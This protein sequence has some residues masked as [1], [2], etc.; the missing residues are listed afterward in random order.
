MIRILSYNIFWKAMTGKHPKCN[1]ILFDKSTG[2]Y[3]NNCLNNVVNF[4]DSLGPY[5][6]V[7]LQEANSWPTI[8]ILSNYLSPMTAICYKP[9]VEDIVVFYNKS[10]YHLD[11]SDNIIKGYLKDKGRPLII[12]FFQENI[13][14]INIHAGHHKDIL[15]LDQHLERILNS[16]EYIA[17][18]FIFLEKFQ[19]YHII[20]MGDFND[21]LSGSTHTIFSNSFF[22]MGKGRT[23]YGVNNKDTCC[24]SGLTNYLHHPR[25][26][27]HILSSYQNIQSK[28][29]PVS[30]ASDHFP[31]ISEIFI[32][33]IIGRNRIKNI[34]YDFDGVLHVDVGPP[35]IYGQRH[36]FSHR[37][38]NL[39][40]FDKII[41]QIYLELQSGHNVF[42]ITA[43]S[44]NSKT[45]IKNF[46]SG[47]IL[48]N[49]L[50][51]I[52]IYCSAGKNK[53]QILDQL[54]INIF[55]DDSCVR[56]LELQKSILNGKLPNME[57]LYYVK[58]ELQTWV[59]VNPSSNTN[60][61]IL[62]HHLY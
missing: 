13:C 18:K 15:L 39:K 6:F 10:K 32:N 23:L 27:D 46:L 8:Q 59:F 16:P 43:R 38:N 25:P 22:Q 47:T 51:S 20:M 52:P 24:N 3:Y 50:N 33:N 11:Y 29:Y 2:I 34:G 19:K 30:N 40:P 4:I 55:Y 61:S 9:G 31:I 41:N 35:D 12:L 36:P 54:R 5:D 14:L 28:V 60:G 57:K 26:I 7:G 42:I 37:T 56:I 17:S 58:P 62:C 44:D 21:P 49:Y 45:L 53:T 48:K 1:Q